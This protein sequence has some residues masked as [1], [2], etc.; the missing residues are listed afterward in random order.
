M[1]RDGDGGG[2]GGVKLS[3]LAWRLVYIPLG[4]IGSGLRATNDESGSYRKMGRS[5]LPWCVIGW[6]AGRVVPEESI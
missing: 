5:S 6:I 3:L 1:D 4:P 2:G